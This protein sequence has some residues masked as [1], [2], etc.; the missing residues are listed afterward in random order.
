MR[1]RSMDIAKDQMGRPVRLGRCRRCGGCCDPATMP[2]RLEAYRQGGAL[3][4]ITQ[5][6]DGCRQFRRE[7][8]RATCAIYEQRPKM[9]R[10]FPI[11]P[12]DIA[13]LPTCGYR[14]VTLPAG[15]GA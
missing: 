15:K 14:F 10:L 2:A 4:V 9:C 6:P 3:A 5:H 1:K 13:A 11:H 8:G 7:N 12:M